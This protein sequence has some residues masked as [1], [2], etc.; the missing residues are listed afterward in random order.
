MSF[1]I[2]LLWLFYT[3]IRNMKS[4]GRIFT[5]YIFA[6]SFLHKDITGRNFIASMIVMCVISWPPCVGTCPKL[7][8]KS[9]SRYY[10]CKTSNLIFH[11]TECH[12][13][14]LSHPKKKFPVVRTKRMWFK[15]SLKNDTKTKWN[16]SQAWNDT[17]QPETWFRTAWDATRNRMKHGTKTAWNKP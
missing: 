17:K 1:T 13:L 14:A 11:E 9:G 12:S 7:Y 15:N 5:K 3:T 8:G 10:S 4:R 2:K 6:N 16:I